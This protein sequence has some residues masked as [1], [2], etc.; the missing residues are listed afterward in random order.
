MT[1]WTGFYT[2]AFSK[3]GNPAASH[4]RENKFVRL[5][6][7]AVKNPWPVKW[8]LLLHGPWPAPCPS[9]HCV[10][11]R[12]HPCESVVNALLILRFALRA[13]RLAAFSIS[14][15]QRFAYGP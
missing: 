7:V 15:C 8:P 4:W 12:V 2:I 11:I 5:V 14:A 13:L 10:K 6:Y 1:R 9:R 3:P